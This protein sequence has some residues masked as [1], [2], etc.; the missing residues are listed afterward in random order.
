MILGTGESGKAAAELAVKSGAEPVFDNNFQFSVFSFQL[1]VLSPGISINHPRIRE[2]K[3]RG[4]KVVSELEFAYRA[5][6]AS[7]LAVTGTNGKSTTVSLLGA[8][9]NKGGIRAEVLGNIGVAFSRRAL[10]LPASACAVLEVSSFQTEAVDRF[11]PHIGVILNLT[12]DHLDR[13]GTLESY[14][15]TKFKMFARQT[16]KDCAVLNADDGEIMKR[17]DLVRARK[18]YF[19]TEKRVRG[20]YLADSGVWF[21]D[22]FSEPRFIVSRG[23]IKLPGRHNLSNA[24]AASCVALLY[25]VSI[26]AAAAALAEFSGIKHRL[27]FV[28]ELDGIKYWNDSKATNIDSAL[29]GARALTGEITQILGGSDKGYEFDAL[30]EGLPANVTRAVA[31]GATAEKLLAAAARR[32]FERIAFAPDFKTAVETARDL[33]GP[34]GNVLLGPACASFDSFRN[35]EHRGDTFCGIVNELKTEN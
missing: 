19:S 30:F 12:P 31:V 34:G 3:A 10:E 11:R 18:Y 15:L 20:C 26:E 1:A 9:L 4:V 25:G 21:W 32:G 29:T 5:C 35:Y 24:L 2:L 6:A 8:M 23:G 14:A 28:R 13:H 17:A 22:G 16:K 27:E 33:T 7:V